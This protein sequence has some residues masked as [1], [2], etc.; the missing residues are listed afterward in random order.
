MA[1]YPLV[2]A[3]DCSADMK[4]EIVDVCVTACERHAADVEKCT[5]VGLEPP[6][7][8]GGWGRGGAGGSLNADV[9]LQYRSKP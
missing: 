3:S 6:G 9:L 7:N 2:A 4:Q 1:K 5:Q 8:G